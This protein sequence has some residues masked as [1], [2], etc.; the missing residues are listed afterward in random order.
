MGGARPKPWSKLEPSTF[1]FFLGPWTPNPAWTLGP[2]PWALDPGPWALNLG[3][4]TLN[5][6][7][8][9]PDPGL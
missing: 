8:G 6:K 1:S 3:L 9:A 4:W 2:G 5:P 7:P